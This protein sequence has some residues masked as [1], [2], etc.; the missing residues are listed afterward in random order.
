MTD[1][2]GSVMIGRMRAFVSVL[3]VGWL[4]TG[5]SSSEDST[6][7]GGDAGSAGQGGGA[8][9]GAAATGGAAG[10]GGQ[11]GSGGSAGMG[12]SAGTG[13]S[14]GAGGSGDP[15]DFENVPYGHVEASDVGVCIGVGVVAPAPTD[16][17]TGP[18]TLT[19]ATTIENVVVDGCLRVEGDGVTL[20]NVV[21][22]CDGLYPVRADG[23]AN[24]TVEYSQVNCTS[25]S[26]VFLV[27]NFTNLTVRKNETTGCQDLFFVEGAVD[28]F[29]AEYNYFR[30]LNIDAAAHAD[31]FQIG[32]FTRTTGQ[33][34]V[35]GNFFH[36]NS[37][38]GKTD[39]VFATNE[40]A[41]DI[42]LEDN[43]FEIWGL[44]TIRCGNESACTVRHNV[45]EQAFENIDY[46]GGVGKLLFMQVTSSEPAAF[47]CNRLEDGSLVEEM[48]G[49][50]DRV[51]G[52][53]HVTTGCPPFPGG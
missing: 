26:K 47:E 52:A 8:G 42:V 31:G 14:A 48:A 24:L 41:V 6:S 12:G 28:G 33:M 20:R 27:D 15:C 4:A 34:T 40:S 2:A 38:G 13:G 32:E 53:T 5:C 19:S 46:P 39:I 49:N 18:M 36:P 43:F 1:G 3:V 30:D 44:R 11:A 22:N 51:A 10:G 50:L 45:Y 37:D 29:T 35:R 17:Y 16:A 25:S 23:A 9:S 7:S 21:I